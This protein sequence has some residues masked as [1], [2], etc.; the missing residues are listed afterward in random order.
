MRLSLR[1]L[2]AARAALLAICL[3]AAP[4]GVS[5]QTSSAIPELW[6]ESVS[7]L[8]DKIAANVSP[9]HPLVLQAH[10]I[11]SL[12][13]SEAANVRAA[14]E[15]ELKNRSFRL[16]PPDSDAAAA[17]S[18]TKL[19]FTLSQNADSYIWIAGL[20]SADIQNVVMVTA[21][22]R[23]SQTPTGTKPSVTLQRNILGFRRQPFLDFEV[24]H[25]FQRTFLVTLENGS[26]D[27]DETYFGWN[28]DEWSSVPFPAVSGYRDS[29]GRLSHNVDRTEARIGGTLCVTPSLRRGVQCGEGANDDWFFGAEVWPFNEAWNTKYVAGRNYFAGFQSQSNGLEGVQPPFYSAAILHYDHGSAWILTEL[30]GTARMYRF[31]AKPSATFHGWGDDIMTIVIGCETGWDVLVTGTGDWTEPDHIQIYEIEN[32]EATA[33]GQPL[34]FPGPILAL[35]PADDG[36]SARVVSRNLQTGM[37]EASIVSVSCGN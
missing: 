34:E 8:A 30:D 3:L 13:S 26:I 12:S 10:N 25:I 15:S 14:L 16:M 6:N 33:V 29:R 7:Q 35:W 9:L 31:S 24:D 17:Q 27:T 37:Y 20:S 32:Q 18:A 5:A 28:R 4:R 11:S 36:K 1:L 19:Q 21:S 2:P 22:K 23:L